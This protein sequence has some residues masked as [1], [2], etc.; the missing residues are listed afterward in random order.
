MPFLSPNQQRQSTEGIQ[1]CT[2][3]SIIIIMQHLTR[4]MSVIRWRIAGA[5]GHVNLRV[6]VSVIKSFEFLIFL[7]CLFIL[8]AFSALTLLVGL[9]EQ[10][11]ACKNWVMRCWCGYLS[12]VRCISFAYGPADAT[13]SQNPSSLASFKSRLVLLFL[14]RL[15]QVV[16][17]K[18]PLNR[19]TS[20][21][22]I[23]YVK[24]WLDFC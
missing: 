6:A 14:Y 4:R 1:C 3:F 18:R 8:S 11:P 12:G 17:E 19:C 24:K 22:Y 9:Q 7:Y 23:V 5:G 21:I 20:S 16:L 2:S 15:T 10:H 13:A